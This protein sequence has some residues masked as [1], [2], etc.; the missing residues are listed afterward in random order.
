MV[1]FVSFR[2]MAEPAPAVDVGN[3][4]ELTGLAQ[5]VWGNTGAKEIEVFS[6]ALGSKEYSLR[7]SYPI[8]PNIYT[9]TLSDLI[10]RS[11]NY[12]IKSTDSC[13][14][15]S[16]LGRVH[17]TIYLTSQLDKENNVILRWTAYEGY[18]YSEYEIVRVENG[19]ASEY[20]RAGI[21]TNELIISDEPFGATNIYYV[22]RV[23]APQS[24]VPTDYYDY[25]W[26]NKSINYGSF[27]INIEYPGNLAMRK[28]YPNPN[29]GQFNLQLGFNAETEVSLHVTDMS[30]R[31]I[32]NK[33]L[34]QVFGIVTTP[35]DLLDNA[36][37]VY[38]LRIEAGEEV[39]MV[40]IQVTK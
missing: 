8:N 4:S 20:G 34:G 9:D 22:I 38:Q 36:A 21:G 35:I 40:R 1:L 17:Q 3:I 25:S 29:G 14:N 28:L 39:F 23:A 5:I 6:R 16:E 19:V 18:A 33:E 24:C 12:T 26:S 27:N 31:E 11:H 13:G 15:K 7:G 2:T 37:G 32:W 10:E 30:G